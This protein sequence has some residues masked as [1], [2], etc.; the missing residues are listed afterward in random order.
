[1]G[2]NLA[3]DYDP[4][5]FFLTIKEIVQKIAFQKTGINNSDC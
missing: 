1:M 2:Q 4:R 5:H 3:K